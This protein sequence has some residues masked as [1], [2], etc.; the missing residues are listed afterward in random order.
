MVPRSVVNWQALIA[1]WMTLSG[2]VGIAAAVLTVVVAIVLAVLVYRD[3]ASRR[4]HVLGIV[5]ALWFLIVLFSSFL[6]VVGYWVMTHS[7]LARTREKPE[8]QPD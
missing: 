6:G 1:G 4:Q 7:T 3:A 5:P 8:T 2:L